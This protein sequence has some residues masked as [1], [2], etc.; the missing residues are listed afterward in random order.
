[1]KIYT[2]ENSIRTADEFS[3]KLP[4]TDL[5]I[6]PLWCADSNLHRYNYGTLS[7]FKSSPV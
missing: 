4:V 5:N 3:T 7:R 6:A 1:V 2:V